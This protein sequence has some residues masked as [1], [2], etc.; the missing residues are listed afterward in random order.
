MTEEE[1]I[2]MLQ[3]GQIEEVQERLS[4]MEEGMAKSVVELA[5]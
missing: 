5:I 2:K 1:A 4:S 3:D